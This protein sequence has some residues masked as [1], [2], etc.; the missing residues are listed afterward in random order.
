MLAAGALI[1]KEYF[2][3]SFVVLMTFVISFQLSQGCIAWL[4]CSEVSVDQA[5]G[6]VMAGQ[7][8]TMLILSFTME[9]LIN[10]PL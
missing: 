10:G 9:F 4:Y 8:I 3:T 6:V 2:L 7:F 1:V 5:S